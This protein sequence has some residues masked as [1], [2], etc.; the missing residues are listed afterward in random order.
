MHDLGRER[1]MVAVSAAIGIESIYEMTRNKMKNTEIDG[2]PKVKNQVLPVVS[3][4][5]RVF[6][7]NST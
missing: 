5:V 7:G 6:L 3:F 2:I 4:P 1:I